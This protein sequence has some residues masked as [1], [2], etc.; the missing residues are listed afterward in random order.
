[1][2]LLSQALIIWSLITT[3][4]QSQILKGP[5]PQRACLYFHSSSQVWAFNINVV[6]N[7]I[8]LELGAFF[9]QPRC[10]FF[11]LLFYFLILKHLFKSVQLFIIWRSAKTGGCGV[12]GISSFSDNFLT[13]LHSYQICSGEKNYAQI[14]VF[15]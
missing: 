5:V 10:N 8:G 11:F 2:Y 13:N 14:L 3:T 6:S 4:L 7:H 1:M 9:C 12:E 15:Q